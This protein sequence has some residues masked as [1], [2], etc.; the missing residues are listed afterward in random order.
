MA[1]V[2]VSLL[3][4]GQA[5]GDAA[6][7]RI[8][9]ALTAHG[10]DLVRVITDR[11]DL[12]HLLDPPVDVV[13]SAGGD[14][15]AAAAA[16]ALAGKNTPLA[17]LPLGTA[18]NIARSLG[19]VGSI[20]DLIAGLRFE[21]RRSLDLGTASGSW[22]SRTFVESVGGGMIAAGIEAM[23][24]RRDGKPPES[25]V[26]RMERALRGYH[27]IIA[28]LEPRAC[29]LL[30]D[31]TQL[32]GDFLVVEVLNTPWIGPNINLSP[33]TDTSDGLLSVVVVGDNERE[34]LQNYLERRILNDD[35]RVTLHA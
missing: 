17:I 4:N 19:Y 3:Y 7:D 27:E 35:V 9:S 21:R 13:L 22:G 6:L 31:G 28:R 24:T 25:A 23:R 14:G 8:R 33:D 26:A 32:E 20:E 15:T 10:H 18:N 30:L 5:A 34:A 2:R 11:A 16:R 29:T 12:P 1:T